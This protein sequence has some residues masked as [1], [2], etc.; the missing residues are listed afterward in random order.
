MSS[1]L[2][3]A[4]I[5]RADYRGHALRMTTPILAPADLIDSAPYAALGFPSREPVATLFSIAHLFGRGTNRCG[6]Y[7]LEFLECRI[8]IGQAVDVVR[9]FGQHR[10]NHAD[11]QAFSFMPCPQDALDVTERE[12]IRRAE[13]QGRVLLNTVHVSQ[14]TGDTDF[15][16]VLSLEEQALWLASP[17]DFNAGDSA[18]AVVL[19]D[20]QRIRFSKQF[21]R[22]SEHP[23]GDAASSMLR[24]YVQ[25]CIPAPKR[26]EYSFWAVSC[27]PSTNRNT[28]PRLFCV[29][30]GVM[31]LLVVGFH[32]SAPASM[33]GFVTIATD[34]LSQAVDADPLLLSTLAGVEMVQRDY[35]DAGQHQVTLQARDCQ[36]LKTLLEHPSIQGAGAQLALRVM[37]KRATIY[38]KFHC[39]PLADQALGDGL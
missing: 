38:G 21:D 19:P 10:K 32:K 22:F 17:A 39:K 20:A 35:R 29:S 2:C 11:I 8:Y 16:T 9:R 33:W 31:E 26:S 13:S 30:A 36:S 6:I 18:T 1:L 7:L 23:I 34:I 25:H 12:L 3:D 27:L 4:S 14:V 37:R 24:T 5:T 28:W 15:D